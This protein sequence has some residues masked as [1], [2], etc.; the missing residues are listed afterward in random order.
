ME[1]LRIDVIEIEPIIN[2]YVVRVIMVDD[3]DV[4]DRIRITKFFFT[5]I[6]NVLA[7]IETNLD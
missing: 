1:E 2:D 6:E 3:D 5:T 7:F 4:D